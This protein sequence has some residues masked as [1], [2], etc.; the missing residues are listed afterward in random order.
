MYIIPTNSVTASQIE[1]EILPLIQV[2]ASTTIM[3]PIPA[4]RWFLYFRTEGLNLRGDNGDEYMVRANRNDAYTTATAATRDDTLVVDASG[5]AVT[6][7]V[8]AATTLIDKRYTIV[9][10]DTS[11]NAVTV[12]AAAG[13][14]NGV[15]SFILRSRFDSV[16]LAAVSQSSYT[17]WFI[18]AFYASG[19]QA[20]SSDA[21][22]TDVSTTAVVT[23]EDLN[24]LTLPANLLS[25]NKRGVRLKAWGTVAGNANAK[26]I[27]LK[28][29]SVTLV[30]ND[31][32]A[33]PNGV[34]WVLR[35]EVYRTAANAQKY[36]AEALVGAAD[37]SPTTG[38]AA[39]TD[40]ATIVA[41]VT[42]QNGV[43]SAG[44]ITGQGLAAE[45][46]D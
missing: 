7:T 16:T 31:V 36:S 44:D 19:A 13:F 30:T 8:P 10:G 20:Y 29:G 32:T 3:T 35:A 41:K 5:G 46:I 17:G 21:H 33:T 6:L 45:A 42:G 26:T 2:P 11:A 15:T 9:K 1:G 12:S 25:A 27:R 43:A 14:I 24:T 38:T 22:L 37:Q 34:K 28:F 18:E 40:T 23:E 4:G 39:E